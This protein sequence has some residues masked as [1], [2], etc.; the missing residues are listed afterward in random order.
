MA[1]RAA[2]GGKKNLRAIARVTVSLAQTFS[3]RAI[4]YYQAV[5]SDAPASDRYSVEYP[6]V[7]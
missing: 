1:R 3:I 5:A 4:S 7:R 2:G 6:D